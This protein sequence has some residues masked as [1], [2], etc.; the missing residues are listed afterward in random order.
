[1]SGLAIT[2]QHE[3]T[4][5]SI[6]CEAK[7]TNFNDKIE[8]Y[9]ACVYLM[10]DLDIILFFNHL[11]CLS[12][13]IPMHLCIIQDKLL[14]FVQ[15]SVHFRPTH[16]QH[17]PYDPSD[18][19]LQRYSHFEK[20]SYHASNCTVVTGKFILSS[21][22]NSHFHVLMPDLHHKLA[23]YKIECDILPVITRFLYI[24]FPHVTYNAGLSYHD[25]I[26]LLEHACVLQ[27]FLSNSTSFETN[28][29][30]LCSPSPTDLEHP[31]SFSSDGFI[32]LKLSILPFV[33]PR[34]I[35]LHQ[36]SSLLSPVRPLLSTLSLVKIL[37]YDRTTG[38]LDKRTHTCVFSV[39]YRLPNSFNQSITFGSK[40]V[41][42]EIFHRISQ[43]T[44]LNALLKCQCSQHSLQ[45]NLDD[46]QSPC[47]LYPLSFDTSQSTSVTVTFLVVSHDNDID[48][49]QED[50]TTMNPLS[51]QTVVLSSSHLHPI[52]E[53]ML[54]ASTVFKE[55]LHDN[56]KPALNYR[57][58]CQCIKNP[59]IKCDD[60]TLL[61]HT[62]RPL[63][64]FHYRA[65]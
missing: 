32:H 38:H 23:M 34:T 20:L 54:S 24:L 49:S 18:F 17:S 48:Y 6:E 28:S 27:Q 60:S 16:L 12:L 3:P 36:I 14:S 8:Y 31:Y 59:I 29:L 19:I 15:T 51:K 7:T 61:D 45:N 53:A 22:H 35:D 65:R 11:I 13:Q 52:S 46:T 4:L 58:L 33:S 64:R 43:F 57:V 25:R 26:D 21:W 9:R 56:D 5:I 1:M 42:I 55:Y 41:P 44:I 2:Q 50:S 40:L 10:H 63:S 39:K 62:V 37:F 47:R 30:M